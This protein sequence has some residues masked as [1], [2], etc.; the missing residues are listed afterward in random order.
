MKYL[1]LFEEYKPFSNKMTFK[2]YLKKYVTNKNVEL[3]Q[4][5]EIDFS[6]GNLDG[7]ENSTAV[8]HS[9]K[10]LYCCTNNLRSLKGIEN[11]TTLTELFCYDNHLE[12]IKEVENLKNLDTLMCYDNNIKSIGDEV[13]NLPR[14][15]DFRCMNN[16]LEFPLP[17]EVGDKFKLSNLYNE[18]TLNEFSSYEFQKRFLTE[19]PEKFMD[20]KHIGF[21]EK[22]KIEFPSLISGVEWGFFDLERGSK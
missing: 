8:A 22:I 11:I 1:K 5:S 21:N 3:M 4:C 15:R 17:A 14:L 2:E 10:I 12:S 13:K 18:K 6:E 19:Q 16:P 9:L 20:L 7:I